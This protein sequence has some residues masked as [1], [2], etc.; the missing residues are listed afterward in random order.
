M[1][2]VV[3]KDIVSQSCYFKS[4]LDPMILRGV[5]GGDLNSFKTPRVEGS[6]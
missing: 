6:G 4:R 3:W 5:G 1:K 2:C